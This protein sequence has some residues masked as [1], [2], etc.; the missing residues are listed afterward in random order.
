MS[1]E[2]RTL[3]E[4][5]R[6]C[7]HGEISSDDL[8]ERKV[9]HL[10]GSRVGIVKS[11]GRRSG[12]IVK[13]HTPRCQTCIVL[14]VE[15]ENGLEEVDPHHVEPTTD[16]IVDGVSGL[17]WPDREVIGKVTFVA[18]GDDPIIDEASVD[19]VSV[20]LAPVEVVLN[21]PVNLPVNS[22]L[23]RPVNNGT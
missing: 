10:F 16:V 12:C 2:T 17:A 8:I 21:V 19:L 20:A 14:N 18:E 22:L 6:A 7:T 4:I 5:I 9:M 1:I 11:I 3:S 13:P 23:D 15:F